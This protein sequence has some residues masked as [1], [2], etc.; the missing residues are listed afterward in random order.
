MA[1]FL[2]GP[3][4]LPGT[5]QVRLTMGEKTWTQPVEILC[6]PRGHE[7]AEGERAQYDL[8]LKINDKLTQAHD[9][10]NAMRDVKKQI[11]DWERRLK[12]DEAA[13]EILDAATALKKALTDIE[14]SLF[15]TE[16]QTDLHYTEK[17]MLSGRMAAL[18][19]AVDFSDHA[20]TKQAVEV[21][22]A[23]AERIDQELE[24]YRAC[25]D[26]DLAALNEK[27]RSAQVP[28]IAPAPRAG[29]A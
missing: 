22:E 29:G 5:Y 26:T 15:K 10:V 16:P 4:V 9:A 20:P 18:K 13:R 21:Y 8:L 12:G 2:A 25:L 7:T 23:L 27:I 11:G 24:R 17:L 1:F 28:T 3:L 6:D 19:F 14:E